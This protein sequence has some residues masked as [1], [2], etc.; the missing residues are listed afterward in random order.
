MKYIKKEGNYVEVRN[1]REREKKGW[2]FYKGGKVG[3]IRKKET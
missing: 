2:K 1:K 3:A